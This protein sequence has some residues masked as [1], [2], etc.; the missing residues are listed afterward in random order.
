MLKILI[1]IVLFGHGVGHSLGLLQTFRV[2]T[3]NPS[4]NGDSWLLTGFAGTTVS[5]AIGVTLW[6][7][8]LVG[9][10][11]SAAVVM[12]WLPVAW[13]EPLAIGSSVASLL[14]LALFPAAFPLTSTV[15]AAIVDVVVLAA[16]LGWHWLPTDLAA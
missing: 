7:I 6:S 16:V 3:V 2:A 13:W 15:A 9:F 4:W 1:A 10:V 11:A 5:Q 14:A 8:A 12:G